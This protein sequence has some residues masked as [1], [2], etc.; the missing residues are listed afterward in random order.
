[1][2]F[3]G[4]G[5]RS[6]VRRQKVF[7]LNSVKD[8]RILPEAV[9]ALQAKI[10]GSFALLRMT[11]QKITPEGKRL[12]GTNHFPVDE[13]GPSAASFPARTQYPTEN[14]ARSCFGFSISST[15]AMA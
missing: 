13:G 9:Q 11:D 3:G 5:S 14:K 10:Q 12:A 1:V 2:L 6:T 7:I 4:S 8:P 15:S